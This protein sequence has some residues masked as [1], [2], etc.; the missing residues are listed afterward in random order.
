MHRVSDHAAPGGRSRITRPPMLP[1]AQFD[2]VG[3]L[4]SVFEAQCLACTYPCQ[5]FAAVLTDNGA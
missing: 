4:D 3:A 1:S 2:S 5:R